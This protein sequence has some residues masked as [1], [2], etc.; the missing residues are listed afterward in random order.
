MLGTAEVTTPKMLKPGSDLCREGFDARS[1]A[2]PATLL[3][4]VP[5]SIDRWVRARID[6]ARREIGDKL[7]FDSGERCL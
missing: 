6:R 5:T 1:R 4:A 3:V 7:G 2:V